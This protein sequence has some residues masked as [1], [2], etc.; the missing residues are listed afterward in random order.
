MSLKEVQD[1]EARCLLSVTPIADESLITNCPTSA[2]ASIADPSLVQLST[3]GMQEI[4]SGIPASQSSVTYGPTWMLA[5]VQTNGTPQL[6]AEDLYDEGAGAVWGSLSDEGGPSLNMLS[7]VAG[8]LGAMGIDDLLQD[9]GAVATGPTGAAEAIGGYGNAYTGIDYVPPDYGG[10]YIGVDD[11]G[12]EYNATGGAVWGT[13]ADEG[14]YGTVIGLDDVVDYGAVDG[15]VGVY[16][17]VDY[18]PPDYGGGIDGGIDDVAD[19][20]AGAHGGLDDV[21]DYGA[22]IGGPADGGIDTG[23]GVNGGEG[24]HGAGDYGP[25][26]YGAGEGGYGANGV[27]GSPAGDYGAGAGGYGAGDTSGNVGDVGAGAG[28]G[29][30]VGGMADLGMDGSHSIVAEDDTASTNEDTAVSI[31][32]LANDHDG[33]GHALTVTNLMAMNGTAS[34]NS[35]GVVTFMP[36]PNFHG[37]ATITYKAT[38]G[39]FFS[40]LATVTVSVA[41]INDVPTITNPSNKTFKE[42]DDVSMVVVAATDADLPN[43]FL[44][45]SIAGTPPGVAI[46]IATGRFQGKLNYTTAGTYNVT[47]TVTDRAGAAASTSFVWTIQDAGFDTLTATEMG[48]SI[49]TSNSITVPGPRDVLYVAPG[50]NVTL[51]VAALPPKLL[52]NMIDVRYV[53]TGNNGTSVGGS[54]L[55]TPSLTMGAAGIVYTVTAYLDENLNAA[56]DAAEFQLTLTIKVVDFGSAKV[57]GGR[58]GGGIL[59]PGEDLLF[60]KAGELFD[61]TSTFEYK[62]V[63]EPDTV[64]GDGAIVRGQLIRPST[65]AVFGNSSAIGESFNVLLTSAM[66]GP[67]QVRFYLDANFNGVYDMGEPNQTSSPF[68]I[69]E[70]NHLTRTYQYNIYHPITQADVQAAVNESFSLALR[71]DRDEDFRAAVDCIVSPASTPYFIP[72]SDRPDAANTLAKIALHL[73]AHQGI[74]ILSNGMSDPV[75]GVY[76]GMAYVGPGQ[77]SLVVSWPDKTARSLVHEIGH[78][79]GLNHDGLGNAFIMEDG[80]L[81]AGGTMDQLSASEANV[82]SGLSTGS[83]GIILPDAIPAPVASPLSTLNFIAELWSPI[84]LA[85]ERLTISSNDYSLLPID[86]SPDSARSGKKRGGFAVCREF[87]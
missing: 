13:I 50:N 56:L 49:S 47:V 65:G 30:D 75:N 21:A 34:V 85:N 31:S 59:Y 26:D 48:G 43:D 44:Y 1:L 86:L 45:F 73:A 24:A 14:V 74:T 83:S 2:T 8:A 87:A 22:V 64:L 20:G 38:D 41:D 55:P 71:K 81:T 67:A 68:K 18:V 6:P 12:E 63:P 77:T 36:A 5:A 19:Y 53:M 23:I 28:P 80:L 52:A 10:G 72:N 33:A 82:Y 46:E 42:G 32:V 69:V 79:L 78:N 16:G 76:Y 62:I 17:G 39:M 4:I 66:V 58:V 9:F 11:V 29:A 60:I 27:I 15:G 25:G 84:Q 54:F 7:N 51:S 70:R 57:F 61:V 3:V 37:V 35:S 40:N